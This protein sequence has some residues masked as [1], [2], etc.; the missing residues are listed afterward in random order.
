MK[1]MNLCRVTITPAAKGRR[2]DDRGWK[3]AFWGVPAKTDIMAAVVAG[4]EEMKTQL[5]EWRKDDELYEVE[6][7]E[8]KHQIENLAIIIEI[9]SAWSGPEGLALDHVVS[10]KVANVQVGSVKAELEQIWVP[11]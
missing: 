6:I 8:M 3:G 7:N 4:A 1:T 2:F 11:K 10:V 9:L 5:D